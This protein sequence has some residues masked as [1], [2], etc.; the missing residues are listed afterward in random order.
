MYDCL[1]PFKGHDL[2]WAIIYIYLCSL[3]I[4]LPIS[5]WIIHILIIVENKNRYKFKRL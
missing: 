5:D 1:R 2:Q 3:F 4:Y